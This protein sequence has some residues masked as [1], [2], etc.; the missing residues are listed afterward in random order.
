MLFCSLVIV[1][2]GTA[3]LTVAAGIQSENVLIL[4]AGGYT[5]NVLDIPMVT[6][7]LQNSA[8]DWGYRT[9]RQTHACQALHEQRSRWPSGRGYG[10]SQILNYMM[11]TRGNPEDYQGWFSAAEK[12][13]Y[14]TDVKP[15]FE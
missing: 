15:Y 7:M 11:W 4:E 8:F 6:P 2:A 10:G 14:E 3:G 5:T 13:D 12:Y 9:S 1:G